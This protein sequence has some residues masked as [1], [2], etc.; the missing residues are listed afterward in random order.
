M[1][2]V[3]VVDML[4]RKIKAGEINPST[5]QPFKVEDIKIQGYRD[6]VALKLLEI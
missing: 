4:V 6:A 2:V 3:S 5:G 1:V